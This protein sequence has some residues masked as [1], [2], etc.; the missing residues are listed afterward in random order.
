MSTTTIERDGPK[1]ESSAVK[2]V[3]AVIADHPFLHEL[4]PEHLRLLADCAM[5]MHYK[6]DELIFREGDPANRFYLIE[7]GKVSLEA[8]RPD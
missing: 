4:R 6:Q 5:R 2:A 1:D 7:Q 3:Q 8:S